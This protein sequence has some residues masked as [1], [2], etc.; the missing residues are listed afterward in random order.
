MLSAELVEILAC[1]ECCG[2]VKYDENKGIICDKCQVAY[3]VKNDIPV[4]LIE[5]AVKLNNGEVND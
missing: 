4:M 2:D 5:Q 3:P 1:P